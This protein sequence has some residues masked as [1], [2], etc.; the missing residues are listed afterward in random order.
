[1]LYVVCSME[2][3]ASFTGLTTWREAHTLVLEIY[4]VTKFFPSDERF[5]L[6][7]QLRRAAVSVSSNIAEGFRR[8]S[9]DEKQ[10]FYEVAQ[11]SLTE[12]QNQLL[13]SHDISYIPKDTFIAI[14]EHSVRVGRLITGLSRSAFS[15]LRPS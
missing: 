14:S 4:R 8:K 7:S 15:Q 12:V 13:I 3:I 10:R 2:K 9:K 11:A 6:V 1:M 5:G